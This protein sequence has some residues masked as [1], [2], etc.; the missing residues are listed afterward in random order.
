MELKGAERERGNGQQGHGL[1]AG[2]GV[3]VAFQVAFDGCTWKSTAVA[4]GGMVSKYSLLT[5][6]ATGITSHT[7]ARCVKLIAG[8]FKEMTR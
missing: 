1:I 5:A 7:I 2:I 6:T 3:G 4:P 8:G